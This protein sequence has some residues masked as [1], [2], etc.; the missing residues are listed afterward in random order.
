MYKVQKNTYPLLILPGNHKRN[1][2]KPSICL[3]I[4]EHYEKMQVMWLGG[5]PAL[6]PLLS[7][8]LWCVTLPTWRW[9]QPIRQQQRERE[10]PLTSTV[11]MPTTCSAH[12]REL[13]LWT[14]HS[15]KLTAGQP[16]PTNCRPGPKWRLVSTQS[17][18]GRG[19]LGPRAGKEVGGEEQVVWGGGPPEWDGHQVGLHGAESGQRACPCF[20]HH[21]C[22]S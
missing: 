14:S 20:W 5:L 10:P 17:E 19:G 7:S 13:W 9:P 18:R 15:R 16:A 6:N 4:L 12:L 8:F 21:G 11:P 1:T 2:M 3:K 22:R